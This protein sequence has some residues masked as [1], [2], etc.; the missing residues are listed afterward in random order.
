MVSV[1]ARDKMEVVTRSCGWELHPRLQC[2]DFENKGHSETVCQCFDDGCNSAD[3]TRP[4]IVTAS[5]ISFILLL[6]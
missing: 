6:V 4:A 2:Y 1:Y 3:L 5:F